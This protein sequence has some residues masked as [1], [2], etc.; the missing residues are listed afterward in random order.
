MSFNKW[1]SSLKF[2]LLAS[3]VSI[4]LILSGIATYIIDSRSKVARLR[5]MESL[6]AEAELI[7]QAIGTQFYERYGDVQAFAINPVLQ[8][9]SAKNRAEITSYLDQYVRLYGIYNVILYVDKSGHFIA[10]N[11]LGIDGK[12]IQTEGLK[13]QSYAESEW[14]KNSIGG[15]FTEDKDKGFTGSYFEDAK[16][17]DISTSA[18]GTAK[19]GNS[20]STSVKNKAGQVIGVITNRANF[21]WVER[22]F[23]IAK[24]NLVGTGLP[25][26]DLHLVNKSNQLLVE[27]GEGESITRDTN[28]LAKADISSRIEGVALKNLKS[29][30]KHFGVIRD[31]NNDQ[32][33]VA[34]FSII[35]NAKWID[36]IG[37]NVV[38]TNKYDQIFVADILMQRN[39]LIIQGLA[40]VLFTFFGW[41]FSNRIS[42]NFMQVA[43]RL[44]RT[45]D[46]SHKTSLQLNTASQAVADS[47][48]DQSA[49][50]QETVSS[51]SEISS[52]ITQTN[53]NVKEC[54]SIASRVTGR[55]EQGN[56]TMR[57]LA[58]AMDAVNHANSQ[59]QNMANIINEVSAKTMV[60]NDI[61]FKTQLLS[62]NA[63]IEAARAGQHGKGFA[64]VAE[65]VG[66]LAQMSGNA[67][68][69]I[70]LLISDSQKQVLQIIEVTQ[71]RSK[72][73][74]NVSQEAVQAFSE[75]ASGIIA[76]NERL[77][78]VTQATHEQEIG[79]QQISIAMT[80]MDQSTQR[81]SS[82]A[83]QANELAVDLGK[84]SELSFR[85]VKALRTIVVG[86]RALKVK[87]SNDIVDQLMDADE[88]VSRGNE[89]VETEGSN[90]GRSKNLL[91]LVGRFQDKSEIRN[92]SAESQ[93]TGL[94][95]MDADDLSFKKPA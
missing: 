86:S 20:F 43:E 95:D 58:S 62:I 31:A 69:E 29:Q 16:T 14:F 5:T 18:Y 75:I 22:E 70:Q 56:Q 39:L 83:A 38:I 26:I 51:M 72:E 89:S 57:R 37:W 60:I 53:A 48:T 10:S 21:I 64:V 15:T 40:T 49:A 34:A 44:G 82:L 79:I 87:K 92:H 32:D 2:K 24:R 47:S 52:M 17:D 36:T 46:L 4:T 9:Q 33:T 28:T 42:K 35:S 73:S 91:N 30:G 13:T 65:E 77:A 71:A 80:Q 12:A 59:L 61:V 76:I 66:N 23:E 94:P 3:T 68:K 81:N 74:Q 11:S 7:G 63:S 50:V 6:A 27:F 8:D 25:N 85:I 88:N 19:F 41:I 84:Q 1:H 78:G 90:S 45:A 93:L 54:T 55:S 67:A